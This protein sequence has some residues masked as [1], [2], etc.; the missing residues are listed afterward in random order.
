MYSLIIEEE[1]IA[2]LGLYLKASNMRG[3]LDQI[4]NELRTRIKHSDQTEIA[5]EDMREIVLQSLDDNG[6]TPEDIHG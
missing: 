4:L 3:A 1:N 2:A 6:L 5:L